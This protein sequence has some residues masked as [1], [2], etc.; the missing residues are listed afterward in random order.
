MTEIVAHRLILWR[1]SE[2]NASRTLVI[3]VST[4]AI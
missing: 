2:A 3:V 1:L 4:L